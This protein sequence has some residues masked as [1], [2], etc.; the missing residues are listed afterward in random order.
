[1]VKTSA[2]ASLATM[3]WQMRAAVLRPGVLTRR[4]PTAC[5]PVVCDCGAPIP[6]VD[7]ILNSDRFSLSVSV[8]KW[9]DRYSFALSLTGYCELASLGPETYANY[10]DGR[11]H[12]SQLAPETHSATAGSW[13]Q[14][15]RWK[16]P[17]EITFAAETV[18]LLSRSRSSKR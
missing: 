2:P 1:M 3:T 6:T 9:P 8:K 14:P 11:L 16:L 5:P 17:A 12:N 13:L 7:C 15:K 4:S 10:G 18:S